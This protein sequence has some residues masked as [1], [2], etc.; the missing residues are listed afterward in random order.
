MS[1]AVRKAGLGMVVVF[2]MIVGSS[3]SAQQ[4]RP[5]NDEFQN[6]GEV[7]T[8]KTVQGRLT[9]TFNLNGR[10]EATRSTVLFYNPHDSAHIGVVVRTRAGARPCR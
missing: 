7:K 9:G 5:P 1:R 4:N 2:A 6:I 8:S 10:A 3:A